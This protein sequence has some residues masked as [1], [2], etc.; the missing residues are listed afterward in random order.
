MANLTIHN[1]DEAITYNLRA[2][3]QQH[4]QSIEEEV[5]RCK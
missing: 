5:S 4:G 3:A 2:Q 1:L